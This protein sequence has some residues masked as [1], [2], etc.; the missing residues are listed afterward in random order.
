MV[1]SLVGV[2]EGTGTIISTR[3]PVLFAI[4]SEEVRLRRTGSA[5]PQHIQLPVAVREHRSLTI[6]QMMS[7]A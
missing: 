5:P 3:P 6:A 4:G 1:R 7:N 2:F